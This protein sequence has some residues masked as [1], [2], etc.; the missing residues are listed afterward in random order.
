MLK[1][2]IVA[3]TIIASLSSLFTTM[4]DKAEAAYNYHAKAISVAKAHLGVPYR[5]GGITPRGFDCSGLVKYSYGK[6]GKTLPRTAAQMFYTKGYRVH[7]LHA[8]DLMFFAPNKASKPTHV[9]MYIGAGKMIMASSSRGVMITY[10][11]NKY[12]KPRYIGAKRI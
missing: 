10:T 4:G 7:S 3:L 2:F 8:G 5:W 6:A 12:W 9:A 1:K 11:N